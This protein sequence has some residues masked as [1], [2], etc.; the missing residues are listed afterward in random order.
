MDGCQNR[1]SRTDRGPGRISDMNDKKQGT[2]RVSGPQLPLVAVLVAPLLYLASAVPVRTIVGTGV[3]DEE[4]FESLYSPYRVVQPYVP[5]RVTE[6][7][8]RVCELVLAI[9][10]GRSRADSAF[11]IE[12]TLAGWRQSFLL[13]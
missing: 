7:P 5:E 10:Y 11:R 1:S 3:I 13:I 6:F 12:S 8:R 4:T 9:G 2:E